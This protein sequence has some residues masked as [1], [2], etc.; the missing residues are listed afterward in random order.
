MVLKIR[1]SLTLETQ[2]AGVVSC[3]ELLVVSC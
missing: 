3:L 1:K 2:P